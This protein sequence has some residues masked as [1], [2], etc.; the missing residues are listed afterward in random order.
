MGDTTTTTTPPT[1]RLGY[2]LAFAALCAALVAAIGISSAG[3]I[4]AKVI[5]RTKHT[6]RPACPNKKN[7]N[8][9]RVVG[10][11]TGFM[12]VADGRKHPFHVS[13]DGKIVA[14]AIDLS[15][16]TKA[17]RNVFG[18]LFQ[19]QELGKAPSARL[20][21][22]KR[23]QK[24]RFKL[25]RQSKAMNLRSSLGRKQIFTLNKPLSVREGQIVAL[26]YPTWAPNFAWNGLS[27]KGNQW[28]ASRRKDNC[29]PKNKTDTA[30]QRFARNSH[31][32]QK[33]G[34]VHNYQCH[35]SGG[36]LLYWAYFVP[37]KKQ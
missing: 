20:A 11:V 1:R 21:V 30:R 33:V 22:L 7:P 26:T 9:C 19:N 2:A 18:T 35:Y 16:P 14:W 28:Q 29:E 32:H 8:N 5:G 15:K 34:S 6:P 4:D 10:R 13:K 36:R 24:N 27:V 23:R 17:E 25:V 3:A 12:T 37:N 31:A